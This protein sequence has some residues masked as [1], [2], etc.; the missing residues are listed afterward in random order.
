M[1]LLP[2]LTSCGVGI[3]HVWQLGFGVWGFWFGGWASWQVVW[4]VLPAGLR[5]LGGLRC[6]LGDCAICFTGWGLWGLLLA[7]GGFWSGGLAWQFSFSW[8]WCN[9][10]FG[11]FWWGCLGVDGVVLRAMAFKFGFW[12]VCWF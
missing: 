9:I 10:G 6:F 7:L 4:F 2:V 8:G 3:I 5:F 1:I 12:F 11:T